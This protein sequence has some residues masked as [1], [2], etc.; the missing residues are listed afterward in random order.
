[1]KFEKLHFVLDSLIARFV[2]SRLRGLPG[3]L[4]IAG[5]GLQAPAPPLYFSGPRAHPRA[6]GC[7]GGA[8]L[9]CPASLVA[10][11]G[12]FALK[13]SSDFSGG[14]A[15][16]GPPACTQCAWGGRA[17]IMWAG[18]VALRASRSAPFG[19]PGVLIPWSLLWGRSGGVLRFAPGSCGLPDLGLR[20][21]E[22]T[23]R[24]L[25][26]RSAPHTSPPLPSGG[27][28][29]AFE[30]FKWAGSVPLVPGSAGAFRGVG[31]LTSVRGPVPGCCDAE[32]TAPPL[33]LWLTFGDRRLSGGPRAHAP[34]A[35]PRLIPKGGQPGPRA[36]AVRLRL[37]IA[38]WSPLASLSS[39]PS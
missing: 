23:A 4:S 20:G 38:S 22:P 21:V 3:A 28:G 9:R 39:R 35:Y 37:S 32:S 27:R 33:R 10:K 36:R 19:G 8:G 34:V 6:W 14:A 30:L 1:M 25:R 29:P 13:G 11:L 31:R 12:S 26:A 15:G 5:L 18:V 7:G 17:V 24:G 2:A 16:S